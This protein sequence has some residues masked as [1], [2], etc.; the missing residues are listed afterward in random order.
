M[1]RIRAFDSLIKF[2]NGKCLKD[3]QIQRII[4]SKN[5]INKK[6][7]LRK[8]RTIHQTNYTLTIFVKK[9]ERKRCQECFIQFNLYAGYYTPLIRISLI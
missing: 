6:L 5:G 9:K 3:L 8:D 4:S 2:Q 1:S 7:E